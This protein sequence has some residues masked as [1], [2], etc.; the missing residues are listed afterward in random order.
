MQRGGLGG[1]EPRFDGPC[2]F[3]AI[4]SSDMARARET[5]AIISRHLPDIPLLPPDPLLNEALPSPM[6]PARPDVPNAKQEIDENHD[7][8]EQAFQKYFHRADIEHRDDDESKHE[9]EVIVGHGNVIRYFFLRA[10]QLPP[11]A[12]LRFSTFNCSI[13]YVMISPNGYASARMVG[14]MGH[15]GYDDVTFSAY[16]G[17]HW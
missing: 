11:E 9:F 6:I 3:K 14:D 10:L 15:I 4:Q 17:L 1:I 13:T 12:W 2:R 8:I 7:R 5:A 16:H